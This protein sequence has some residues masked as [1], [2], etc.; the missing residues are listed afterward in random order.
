MCLSVRWW[1]C[2]SHLRWRRRALAFTTFSLSFFK[3]F[4]MIWTLRV[5]STMYVTELWIH[6]L[7]S[8]YCV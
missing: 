4:H 8:I 5:L 6:N 1:R 2:R 7:K 3:K